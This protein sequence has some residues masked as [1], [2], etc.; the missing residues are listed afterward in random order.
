MFHN[1]DH[2]SYNLGKTTAYHTYKSTAFMTQLMRD[3]NSAVHCNPLHLL[4]IPEESLNTARPLC[5]SA[6]LD[7][8]T[9]TVLIHSKRPLPTSK[10]VWDYGVNN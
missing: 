2:D 6:C 9:S 1:L 7:K 3:D 5:Y 4:L 10:A 8:I